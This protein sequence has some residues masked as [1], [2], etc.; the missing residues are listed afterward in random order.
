MQFDPT[1][2]S[3]HHTNIS[4]SLN[5]IKQSHLQ[6]QFYLIAIVVEDR[7]GAFYL[8]IVSHLFYLQTL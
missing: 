1:K 5:T 4:N 6:S 3:S 2:S 8:T 7:D